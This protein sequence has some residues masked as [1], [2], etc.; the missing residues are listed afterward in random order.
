M[1][2]SFHPAAESEFYDAIDF[3]EQCELGLGYDFSIEVYSCI[4]NV[5]SFPELWPVLEGDIRRC[6]TN[7]FPFGILYNINGN[8]IFILAIMHLS[9]KP[10]YWK[11]RKKYQ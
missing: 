3:Y 9:K 2:F 11:E 8:D 5:L 7:R 6:L 4:N 10:G 1:T